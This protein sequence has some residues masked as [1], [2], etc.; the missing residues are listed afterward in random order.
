MFLENEYLR[1]EF[2]TI[3]G[4][5]TS[6]KDKDGVEY[7]WQGNPEYW[8][9]Q[10][11]V[12]F[13]IC[14]SVRNDKVMFKKAGKEGW[15]AL[16]P[17]YNL[18]VLFQISGIDP[19]KLLWFLLPFIGQIIVFVYLIMAYINLAKAFGK[20]SGFAA[21]LIFL[22]VVFMGILAFDDSVYSGTSV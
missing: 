15:A 10:A 21:G 22:N 14:G 5:L 6:I 16:I 9:G 1:V 3:G 2:S 20:S 18:V 17:I 8:G 7:L 19:K 12:L 11:P 4:A 13:P